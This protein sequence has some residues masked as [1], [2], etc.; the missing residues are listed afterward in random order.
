MKISVLEYLEEAAASCPE[1]KALADEN[2]A[3][4]YRELRDKARIIGSYA[5]QH[6]KAPS[7]A[8]EIIRG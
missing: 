4:S 2:E 5:A 8:V 6:K 1:R 7:G 3:F